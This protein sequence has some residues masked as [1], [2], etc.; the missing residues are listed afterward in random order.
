VPNFGGRKLPVFDSVQEKYTR[1][2][3]NQA[4]TAR[5]LRRRACNLWLLYE[6]LRARLTTTCPAK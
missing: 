3:G 1:I 5:R 2:S 6:E 4:I